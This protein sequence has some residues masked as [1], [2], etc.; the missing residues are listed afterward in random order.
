MSNKPDL[1]PLLAETSGSARHK[2][3]LKQNRRRPERSP[4]RKR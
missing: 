2:D 4:N 1:N 3:R